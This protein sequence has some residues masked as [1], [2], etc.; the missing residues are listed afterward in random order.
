MR[1]GQEMRV[2]AKDRAIGL[3]ESEPDGDRAGRRLRQAAERPHGQNRRAKAGIEDRHHA[4]CNEGK[5]AVGVH[6]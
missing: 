1:L 6:G 4:R 3:L 2:E 5:S